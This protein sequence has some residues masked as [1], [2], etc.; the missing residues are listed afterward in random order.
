MDG[1][2]AG[3]C[4]L[5]AANRAFSAHPGMDILVP[6][7]SPGYA[8]FFGVPHRRGNRCDLG[9]GVV[10]KPAVSGARHR[11]SLGAILRP[12]EPLVLDSGGGGFAGIY[13]IVCC[14]KYS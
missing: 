3:G 9:S 11:E 6:P 10:G 4:F 13:R 2:L 8:F 7:S 14:Q 5:L 1:N 12:G